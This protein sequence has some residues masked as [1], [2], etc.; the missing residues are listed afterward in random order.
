MRS[1]EEMVH[2]DL[3]LRSTIIK[4]WPYEGKE[5]IDLRFLVFM[6]MFKKVSAS[7]S[8]AKWKLFIVRIKYSCEPI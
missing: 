6:N 5:K 3:E 2:A 7:S 1:A 4:V 8:L